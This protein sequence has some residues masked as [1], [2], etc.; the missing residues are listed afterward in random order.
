M[1]HRLAPEAGRDLDGIWYYVATSSG[2]ETA[3][4]LIDAIADRF[5]L[6][7]RFPRLGRPRDD[8]LRQGLRSFAVGQYVI[9]YRLEGED[10]LVLHVTHGHRNIGRLLTE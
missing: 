5:L 10:V 9:I 1:A 7:A 4:R 6:L 2:T 3:D 8:D